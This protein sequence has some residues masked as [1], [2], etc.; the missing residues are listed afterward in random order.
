MSGMCHRKNV[1]E[2]FIKYVLHQQSCMEN[3]LNNEK[4]L[5]YRFPAQQ[6]QYEKLEHK[7]A[8]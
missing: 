8:Q 6:K 2:S 1:T 7:Q 3:V 4:I 5:K